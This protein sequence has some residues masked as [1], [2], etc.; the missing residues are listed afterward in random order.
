MSDLAREKMSKHELT[1]NN[2]SNHL[3][4]TKAKIINDVD[5]QEVIPFNDDVV[6]T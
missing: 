5:D 6:K 4:R 3:P 2:N 1:I